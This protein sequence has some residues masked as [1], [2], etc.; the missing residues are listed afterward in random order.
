MKS[1]Y[2]SDYSAPK[3]QII[4]LNLQGSLMVNSNI[5]NSTSESF[6]NE[7]DFGSIW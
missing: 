2:F 3:T 1:N 6:Q 5:G 7:D 4:Y